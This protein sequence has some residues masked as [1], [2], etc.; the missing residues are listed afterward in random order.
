MT[1]LSTPGASLDVL[2]TPA[3]LRAALERDARAGLSA[4]PKWLPP[5]YFYDDRGSRLFEEITRLPEYYPTRTEHA[6]LSAYATDIAAAADAEVLLEL[7]SGSSH[8]TRLLLNAMARQATLAAYVPVDVSVG[9]LRDAMSS[10][11]T[12]YP[13]LPLHGAVADFDA[14][15][16]LLPAPGRRL[17]V[18]LGGTIGNYPPAERAVLLAAL[19]AAMRPGE[20]FLLGIDLVKDPKRLVA[21]YDD[22]AG[23]TAAF[24]RNVISVLD[25]ELDGDLDPDDFEHVALWDAENEWIEMRLRARRPISARLG[26]LDLPVRLDVEEEIRTEISAKFRRERLAEEL[27]AAGLHVEQWW[28]DPMADFAL[29]LA[30]R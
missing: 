6:I 23:V 18:L 29:V 12:D 8:K 20:A 21:A 16:A 1:T 22:A 10:L 5:K 28:T 26:A 27:T 14:H 2:L 19:S 24:N 25:R 4:T 7:G 3:D 30:R 17:W 15:L 13:H 11:R 9:A